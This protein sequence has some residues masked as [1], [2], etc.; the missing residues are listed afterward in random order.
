G[1]EGGPV[2]AEFPGEAIHRPNT[3]G[4]PE[5]V[6]Q[7]RMFSDQRRHPRP[8]WEV[9]QSLDEASANESASAKALAPRPAKRLKLLN[10][11]LDFGRIEEFRNV[12]YS[13]A[14]RYLASC[15]A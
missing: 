7:P 10:Q 12:A 9:E 1:V 15:H 5:R 6:L 13:R 14:T 2:L 4:V 3:R 11:S 8:G